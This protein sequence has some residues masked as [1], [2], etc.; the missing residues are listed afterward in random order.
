DPRIRLAF[1]KRNRG[2][3]FAK[4]VGLYMARGKY[5]TFQDSDDW[6]HPARLR[7]QLWRLN[8]SGKLATRCNYVR[9]HARMNQLVKVNGRVESPG[10]ITLMAR[11]ELFER[12]GYFDCSRRA[13]D[14]ELI[15]RLQALHGPGAVDTF[16]LP[17][18]VA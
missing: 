3:Y 13:A 4:N 14:D 9:H 16:A 7:L 5:V 11:R 12:Y 2:T 17:A 18:Y 8:C 6:S 15:C 1:L 10:F